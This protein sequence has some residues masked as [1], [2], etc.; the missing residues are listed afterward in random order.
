MF[1]H[2]VVSGPASTSWIPP[3]ETQ[4]RFPFVQPAGLQSAPRQPSA[5]DTTIGKPQ[6]DASRQ[7]S[8][9][10]AASEQLLM[11]LRQPSPAPP[12]TTSLRASSGISVEVS[13]PA[14]GAAPPPSSPVQITRFPSFSENYGNT[15]AAHQLLASQISRNTAE[16]SAS[17]SG[18][19]LLV[20]CTPPRTPTTIKVPNDSLLKKLPALDFP[21]ILDSHAAKGTDSLLKKLPGLDFQEVGDMKATKEMDEAAV[22]KDMQSKVQSL[23]QRVALAQEKVQGIFTPQ[24]AKELGSGVGEEQ[25][26]RQARNVDEFKNRL[27]EL[28]VSMRSTL[29]DRL[30]NVDNCINANG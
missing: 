1:S 15:A 19:A 25:H 13:A 23:D 18:D 20:N 26:S 11:S 2:T 9:R 4:S 21:E 7:L 14:P 5:A 17:K 22:V 12:L 30:R 29:Q 8:E 6:D 3:S 24:P 28:G 10:L 27:D 16:D